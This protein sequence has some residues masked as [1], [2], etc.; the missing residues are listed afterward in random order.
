MKKLGLVLGSGGARGVA[1]IGFL[2]AL[3]ENGIKPYCIAGC[4]MGAVVGGL[5]AKGMTPAEMLEVIKG[6]KASDIVD[7]SSNM[8]REKSMLKTV[9]MA[10]L[11]DKFY[12]DTTFEELR[13]PFM[14]NAFDL[15][16][17]KTVW[18]NTGKVAPCVRAS[19]SIPTVFKPVEMGER[20][21]VDG[22]VI[23]RMPVE[24]VYKMGAD[25]IVGVDV[26]GE[27][28]G[29]EHDKNIFTYVLRLI[30]AVD[31][32]NASEEYEKGKYD[33]LIL[34]DLGEMSQYV[35]KHLEFAYERGYDAGLN[36][37]NAIKELIL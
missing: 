7:L 5:Y 26:L 29:A 31:W 14:C 10:K 27:P 8:I 11:I 30:E 23:K 6:L 12:G 16:K 36:S 15:N 19:A 22:G 2:Q 35:V 4:S 18:F 13:I 28:K 9:K 25:A 20:L 32:A 34:P 17:G 24:A 3:D 1:H 37:V 33:I 21:L